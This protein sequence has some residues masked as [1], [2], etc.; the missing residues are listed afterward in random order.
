MIPHRLVALVI[1]ELLTLFRDPKVR[2]VLIAP[3]LLQLFLFSFAATLEVNNVAL[4]VYNQDLGKHGHEL[5]SRLGG[6]KTF[7]RILFA[8]RGDAF[9][10]IIDEQK[11]IAAVH[12]PQ[13]FSRK[14]E[15]GGQAQ[16]QI[17][18]DGRRSNAAQIV[19]GYIS[20]LVMNYG[21]EIQGKKGSHPAS[22]IVARNWF[23]ENLLYMWFTV[24]SLVGVLA[25]LIT[26]MVTALSVAREKELGTFDQL[27]V[28]PL[29]PYEILMGKTIPA[30]LVGLGESL[31]ILGV[32]IFIF[33]IP[34]IG[35]FFL[36]ALTLLIFI[37]SVVG[38]GLFISA[39]VKTQQQAILGTFTFMVPS[40]TLSGFAAPI[41]NMPHWLQTAT[42]LNPLRH[43]LVTVRGLFLKD[44]PLSEVWGH[45]WPLLLIGVCGLSLANW[46]FTTRLE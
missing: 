37:L 6:S 46:F 32:S 15:E 12:I 31:L 29:M 21:F 24:P 10:S 16:L 25:M 23:N 20:Q 19:N 35:S 9:T 8:D 7:T 45:T 18:L 26:L 33:K 39:L 42:L 11:A 22:P 17:I 38:V 28:S 40:I 14:L 30:I 34:F 41:E 13:D 43:C 4:A 2:I 3:P 44:L 5:V 27:L 36:L 1:K